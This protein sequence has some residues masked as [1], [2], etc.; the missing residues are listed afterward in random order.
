MKYGALIGWGICI[1]AIM[2]LAWTGLALYGFAGTWGSRV[3]EL[4]VLIITVTIAG[5]SLRFNSWKDILPYSILW[6]VIMAL[7]DAVYT[8][9]LS[10]WGIYADWNLWLG[11]ALVALVPLFAPSTRMVK[12]G[13]EV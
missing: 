6:V 11:Y 12:V 3:A 7:L 9:P 5:R 2:T 10:G 1:Y 4:I 13:H 8:V